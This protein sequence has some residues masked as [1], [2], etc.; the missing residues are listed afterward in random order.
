MPNEI[1]L[2]SGDDQN[3]ILE[4]LSLQETTAEIIQDT[5]DLAHE[6]ATTIEETIDVLNSTEEIEA[7]E[8]AGLLSSITVKAYSNRVNSYLDKLESRFIITKMS[9]W[10]N[11][12]LRVNITSCN[13]E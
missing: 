11:S 1:P 4:E 5:T 10:E 12:E 8:N 6:T 7:A 3:V 13:N 2:I 9:I